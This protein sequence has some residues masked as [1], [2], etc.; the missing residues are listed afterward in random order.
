M[1]LRVKLSLA[2]LCLA[3]SMSASAANVSVDCTGRAHGSFTSIT[4]ALDSLVLVPA[5]PNVITVH[6]TCNEN[7]FIFYYQNL[8]IQSA[9]GP[10]AVIDAANPADIVLQAFGCR[11]LV[12]LNLV[13]EGGTTG[14]LLNQASEAVIQNLVVKNQYLRWRKS[15]DRLD[16]GRRKQQIHNNGGNG[17]SVGNTSNAT[18]ATSP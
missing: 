4:A 12:L 3:L 16:A 1:K 15:P 9:P 17:L 6:G 14:L 18:L 7:V 2:V 8:T 11:G 10:S 5:G 13:I